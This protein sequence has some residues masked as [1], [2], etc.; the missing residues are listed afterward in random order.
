MIT[1]NPGQVLLT[2]EENFFLK[3]FLKE[4]SCPDKKVSCDICPFMTRENICII[5]RLRAISEKR[6]YSR[7]EEMI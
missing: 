2:R 6:I 3:M 5:G 1:K 4:V 7:K